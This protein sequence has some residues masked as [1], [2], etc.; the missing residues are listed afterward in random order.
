MLVVAACSSNGGGDPTG[1]EGLS[2]FPHHPERQGTPIVH[3]PDGGTAPVS[4]GGGTSGADAAVAK[5]C[6]GSPLLAKLGKSRMMVGASMADATAAATPF[7]FRYL[8]IAGGLFDSNVCS[9]CA[10]G[11]TSGG[12]DCSNNGPT[13]NWWGCWQSDQKP[14]GQYERDFLTAAAAEGKIPMISYYTILQAS[15]VAEGTAEATEA[16]TNASFMTRYLSDFRF[17]LQQIGSTLAFVHIEP[18]FWGYAQKASTDPHAAAAVASANPTDCGS[19]ENSIAGL[20]HCMIA[21]TRKYAP[22]ALVGLHASPWSTNVDVTAN[23]SPSFDVAAEAQKTAAYLTAVGADVSDFI[24]VEASDRDAGYYDTQ[25]KSTWWDATNATLPSFH[26][27]FA[28]M[29]ALAEAAQKP[30]FD[31]QIPVGNMS[32]ANTT[33]AWHDN[34]V[35]Y[36]FAHMDELAAAHVFAIAYGAGATGMTTPESDSGNLAGK[37]QSYV[38][39]GGQTFCP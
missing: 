10:S 18:D 34:R 12:L 14:P 7:D 19:Q 33:N 27:D 35:D 24:V 9:S 8:Y 4:T 3:E 36:F 16:A 39:S 32:L 25:G 37:V 1:V 11:C 20:G 5:S 23:T 21:M 13:C 30:L 6:I 38:T 2:T 15:G 26:Q 31:W 28:W 22:N 29:K 17:M